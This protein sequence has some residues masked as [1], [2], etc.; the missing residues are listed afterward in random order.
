MIE[1]EVKEINYCGMLY[2]IGKCF[3]YSDLS[4]NR[5]IPHIYI[6][7]CFLKIAIFINICLQYR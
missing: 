1:E 3:Q 7:F 5:G 4:G 6:C 2:R